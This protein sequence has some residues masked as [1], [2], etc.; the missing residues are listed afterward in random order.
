MGD[1]VDGYFKID[2]SLGDLFPSAAR[3]QRNYLSN[4]YS[5]KWPSS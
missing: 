2:G 4:P 1:E 3:M 5:F